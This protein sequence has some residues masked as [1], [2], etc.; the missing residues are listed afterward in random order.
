MKARVEQVPEME[1]ITKE[2]KRD[3]N[4]MTTPLFAR[5]LED[6]SELFF[7]LFVLSN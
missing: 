3:K 5:S 2:L 4:R 1:D 7:T 6:L